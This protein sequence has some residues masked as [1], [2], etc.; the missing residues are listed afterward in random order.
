[1]QKHPRQMRPGSSSLRFSSVRCW[2]MLAASFV[3]PLGRWA[4]A[5]SSPR[6]CWPT[7]R[8]RPRRLT[9]GLAHLL[10]LPLLFATLHLVLRAPGSGRNGPVLESMATRSVV[11]GA[12]QMGRSTTSTMQNR[13]PN[14]CIVARWSGGIRLCHD[15]EPDPVGSVRGGG[16]ER[17]RFRIG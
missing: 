1:M 7:W 15:A 5:T 13:K 16:I 10:T 14:L 6:T 9:A 2:R 4:L 11:A 17:W 8:R 12:R 3:S